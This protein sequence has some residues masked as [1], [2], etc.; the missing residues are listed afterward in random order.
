MSIKDSNSSVVV[1]TMDDVRKAIKEAIEEHA[2]SRN[3]PYATQVEPGFVTLSNETDSDS[4]ITVATSKA[5]KKAYDLANT[6]NQNALNNNSNLYL[7]KKQNGTD[8]PDK[9]EFVKNLDLSELAYRTIGNGPGQIPDMSFFKRYGDTQNGWVQ[10]PNGLIYQ[11]GLSSTRTDNEV[12][13][14]FP[15]QFSSGVSMISE[16]DNSGNTAKAVWQINNISPSGFLATNLGTLRRGIDSFTP[17]V[18]A[19]CQWHAWGF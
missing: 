18:Q 1:P 10:Y 11:W 4:E 7:E 13:V 2:A 3:H 16:H 5:V 9:A 14:S 12:Y 17:P 8:I 6:A 15:I 19:F